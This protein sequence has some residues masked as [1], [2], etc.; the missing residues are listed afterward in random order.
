LLRALNAAYDDGSYAAPAAAWPQQRK[1]DEEDRRAEMALSTAWLI[2]ES[3]A[4]PELRAAGF[5][6]LERLGGA[7]DLGTLRDA[8][9]R[10]GRG[11]EISW[12]GTLANGDRWSSAMRLIFDSAT[13]EILSI[14]LAGNVGDQPHAS[15]HTYLRAEQVRSLPPDVNGA[16]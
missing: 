16:G 12:G 4:T 1:R 3:N 2:V 5:G 13:G 10:P 7:R 14:R 11:L 9:G 15:E 6:V 8:E